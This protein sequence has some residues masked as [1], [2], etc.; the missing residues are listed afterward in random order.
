[1]VADVRFGSAATLR[2]DDLRPLLVS[3]GIALAAAAT[4]LT[5]VYMTPT[6]GVAT[7]AEAST[8]STIDFAPSAHTPPT[9]SV[10]TR[11]IAGVRETPNDEPRKSI[12]EAQIAGIFGAAVVGHAIADVTRLLPGAQ[13]IH[14][15]VGSTSTRHDKSAMPSANPGSTPGMANLTG[16]GTLGRGVEVG[17]VANGAA[18]DRA[19]FHAAPLPRVIAPTL[20][21]MTADATEL[22]A[23]V[24]ARVSQLQSCYERAGG[25][26]LAGVVALRLTLSAGGTIRT[27]EIVRRT[28]SGPGA[29]AAEECLI[30]IARGWRM[31]SGREGATVTFPI[32]FTHGS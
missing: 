2:D 11:G 9:P 28:W 17:R 21:N 29:A 1:M 20:D 14:A 31:P 10:S 7:H 16:S 32:S 12:S 30:T 25:T 13:A 18:I 19:H 27:A 5:A 6:I 15:D 8:P 4:W 23:F 22:G 26:D 3:W 24:R